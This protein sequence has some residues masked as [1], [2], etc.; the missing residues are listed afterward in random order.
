[1]YHIN[2]LLYEN[3][4]S[5]FLVLFNCVLIKPCFLQELFLVKSHD[6]L[7]LSSVMHLLTKGHNLRE[8][9]G[10]SRL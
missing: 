3:Y 2:P 4:D 9:Y 6:S 8:F 10:V 1:M 7:F 5:N